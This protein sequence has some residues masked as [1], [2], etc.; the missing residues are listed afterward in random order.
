VTLAVLSF[1]GVRMLPMS[2]AA[3]CS[4]QIPRPLNRQ[5]DRFCP[6]LPKAAIGMSPQVAEV[7]PTEVKAVELGLSLRSPP[8]Q[9][10]LSLLQNQTQSL[11]KPVALELDLH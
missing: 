5:R 11:A 8:T 9:K 4:P 7:P 6:C 2:K 1:L 3:P 10:G